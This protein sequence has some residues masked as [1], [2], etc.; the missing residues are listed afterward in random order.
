MGKASFGLAG[1]MNPLLTLKSEYVY[2]NSEEKSPGGFMKRFIAMLLFCTFGLTYAGSF[3]LSVVFSEDDLVFTKAGEY[4]V[5]DL[6]GYPCLV[7]PGSPRLPRVIL[8]VLVPSD[9]D[10]RSVTIIEKDVARIPGTY[11]VIPAQPDVPLPMPG[12]EIAPRIHPADAAL[13]ASE[14]LYPK[15][16]IGLAGTGIKNGFRVAHVEFYPLRYIAA[17]RILEFARRVTIEVEYEPGHDKQFVPTFRQ[18]EVAV[19]ALRSIVINPEEVWSFAP[20]VGGRIP[21][22]RVPPGYY[23]YVV[24]SAP[25]MDTVFQRL[26]EWKTRKGVPATVV[27]VSWINTNYTGYDLQEKIRNFIIDAYTNWGTIYVLLGG[28]A[29]QRTS[30]QN[31]VPARRAF[32]TRS[33]VGGYPDEDTIPCDLYY[34]DLNGTWDLDGDHVCGCLCWSCFCI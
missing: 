1:F 11:N 8:P 23:E 2:F 4:D 28:S 12:M 29:D 22:G 15:Q 6:K 20:T 19:Q 25:P 21:S 34:S 32:Y 18:R 10:V 16:E 7:E 27:N 14:E 30:G 9:A 26:A 31:I 5:V 33:F 13:Y 3:T 24:I 17:E